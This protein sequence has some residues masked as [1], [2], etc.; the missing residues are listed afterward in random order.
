MQCNRQRLNMKIASMPLRYTFLAIVFLCQF[1]A[2]AQAQ[3]RA[4]T[5]DATGEDAFL[6]FGVPQ[7]EDVGTSLWCKIGSKKIT[8]F[9]VAPGKKLDDQVAIVMTATLAGKNYALQAHSGFASENTTASVEVDF[10]I[11]DPFLQQLIGAD[12][13]TLEVAGHK[14]TFPLFGADFASLYKICATP[15]EMEQ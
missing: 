14:S 12:L 1:Y 15:P 2:E 8:M 10:N 3:E 4:W 5:L 13:L 6:V 7:T 11:G 9:H